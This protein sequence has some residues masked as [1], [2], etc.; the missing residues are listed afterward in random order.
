M[1]LF[2]TIVK[3]KMRW[4]ALTGFFTL[5]VLPIVRFVMQRRTKTSKSSDEVIDVKA[6]EIK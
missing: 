3:W 6:E 1:S 5:I 4:A 2:A